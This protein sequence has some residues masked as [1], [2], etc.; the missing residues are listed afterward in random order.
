LYT[1]AAVYY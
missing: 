1:I